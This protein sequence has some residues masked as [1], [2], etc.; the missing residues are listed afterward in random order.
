LIL[1]A[2]LLILAVAILATNL[3]ASPKANP[4]LRRVTRTLFNLAKKSA[5]SHKIKV[6]VT[7]FQCIAAAPSV[8]N[9]SIPLGLEY[10]KWILDLIE[11][12]ADLAGDVL[13]PAACIG[14]YRR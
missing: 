1:C 14:S 4:R 12:P 9:M 10:T 3:R 6:L 5:L 11:L 8:Y 13:I 2:L 7:T